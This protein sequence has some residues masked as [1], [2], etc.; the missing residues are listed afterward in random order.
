MKEVLIA[1]KNPGKARE[2]EALFSP[3]D[4][5]VKTLLDYPEVGD[6]E[7]TGTTF[8]ENAILKAEAIA[9]Q[10]Q[11]LTIADDSGLIIDALNGEPGVYSARYAGTEKND[12]KNIDKVLK[13]LLGVPFSQRT[14]RFH[15]TLAICKPDEEAI[16]VTGKC[17]GLI[18]TQRMG[19]EGFGYDPIFWIRDQKRTLAQMSREEKGAISHRGQAIHKLTQLLPEIVN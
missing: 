18:L 5:T 9:K 16:T 6:V 10:F 17:E 12:E 13:N 7:E 19:D 14:A 4:I 11:V 1:T 15:C 3:L 8:E 2:F